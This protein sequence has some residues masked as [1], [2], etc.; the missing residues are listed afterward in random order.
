M[1]HIFL[2]ILADDVPRPFLIYDSGAEEDQR[3]IIFASEASLRVLCR[4][5][6]W[7]KNGNLKMAP[8]IFK[9]PLNDNN[10]TCVYAF[11]SNKSQVTYTEM[12]RAIVHK[13][14]N[15]GMNPNPMKI[16]TDFEQAMFQ[17]IRI[18]LNQYLSIH[19]CFYHLTRSTWRKI[20]SLGLTD[21]YKEN[22]DVKHFCG[23]MDGLSFLPLGDILI[24]MEYLRRIVIPELVPLLDYF[25]K[26]YVSGTTQD[27]MRVTPPT[28]P[29]NLWNNRE[30]T[31]VGGARTNN[32][33]EGWNNGYHQLVGYSHPTFWKSIES[34][35]KDEIINY[36]D[37]IRA[38]RG[39]HTDS[40][41]TSASINLQ[42]RLEN[43]C[44]EHENGTKSMEEFLQA[45]GHTIRMN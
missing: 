38:E 31:M 14:E 39:D 15:L 40:R 2:I 8:R 9:Q 26:N 33:C 27:N 13:C 11:L 21:L 34:L 25:D 44:R 3:I 16:V 18:T 23:M 22:T 5:N 24:G 35:R 28:F 29:P 32:I 45:I 37:I 4:A 17:S 10:I 19:G 30:A 7:N 12:L 1:I 6:I 36:K 20:Q 42:R 41:K 43:L